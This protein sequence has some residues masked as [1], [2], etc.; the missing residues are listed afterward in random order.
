MPEGP[1]IRRAADSLE[2]A[3]KG[4]PLTEVWFAF[5]QLQP[6][7]P[8]LVGQR[9]THIETRGKALLTHFSGGLTLYSHNQLYGVWRVAAA[10]E[11]PS[12]NRILRVRLQ[13]AEKAVLLYSASDI[14]ILTPAQLAVHPF[15]LRVGP[16]V[17]DMTLTPEEVKARLLSAKFRQRQFSGLLLDQ[18][19]LAGLGNY[20]RVEILWQVGLTGR[21][22]ASELTD[23][24]LDALAQALLE[25]PRLSYSTRGQVDDNLHHGA[26]FRFKV[27]HRDGEP[28][29]RCGT[30]IERTMLSSR[31][32]YWCPGCQ[33]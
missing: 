6:W 31:P 23:G 10:G 7:Q 33:L 28:C 5:P 24:Q 30:L 32:F 11:R 1:E 15:L 29:E 12:T 26:L 13:T 18:A 16:D 14:E 19:F 17:L 9:V 22:K 2:L 20:L 3:I 25:I 8:E 4:E 21:H 27:F